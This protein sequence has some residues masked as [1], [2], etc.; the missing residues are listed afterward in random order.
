VIQYLG[1]RLHGLP[2]LVETL[3]RFQGDIDSV[4]MYCRMNQDGGR[5]SIEKLL[6]KCL[7]V[8]FSRNFPFSLDSQQTTIQEEDNYNRRLPDVGHD[9]MLYED[10]GRLMECVAQVLDQT[11]MEATIPLEVNALNPYRQM[12]TELADGLFWFYEMPRFKAEQRSTRRWQ[13]RK[14]SGRLTHETALEAR[15]E[16]NRAQAIC[17]HQA[18]GVGDSYRYI[19]TRGGLSCLSCRKGRRKVT[20]Q[21]RITD[22]PIYGVIRRGLFQR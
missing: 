8:T 15:G 18:H 13:K 20:D 1:E 2:F 7:L 3:Q 6:L 17:Q 11:Y 10:A 14:E 16:A 12:M 19:D 22:S 21:A 4:D 5:D 9:P